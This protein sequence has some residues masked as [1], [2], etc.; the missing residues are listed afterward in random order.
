M[1]IYS[2]QVGSVITG[3]SKE[4]QRKLS[5]LVPKLQGCAV[6][7]VKFAG[8]FVVGSCCGCGGGDVV[9]GVVGGGVVLLLLVLGV[10]LLLLLQCWWL[11]DVALLLSCN[12]AVLD[13]QEEI[14]W[15]K[16]RFTI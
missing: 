14:M 6:D 5:A 15:L 1:S 2:G 4:D 13:T 10:F 12:G 11:Q 7:I 8:E 9:V 16:N 3:V